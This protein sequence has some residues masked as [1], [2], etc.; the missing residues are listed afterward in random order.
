[1]VRLFAQTGSVGFAAA[2]GFDG[3]YTYDIVTYTGDKFIRLCAQAHAAHLLCAPSVGPGYDAVRA[4]GDHQYKPRR[5][6]DTYDAMWAAGILFGVAGVTD[7]IDGFLAR[8]WHVESRFGKIADPLA[9]RLMIDA[10]VIL[11]VAYGRLPW[12]ALA[13]IIARDLLL[14]A[15]YRVLAPRGIDIDVNLA[16]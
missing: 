4:D 12:A 3:I 11:L 9:D 10:A 13:V 6:G 2:A 14:L 16:G 15:G 8:R 5:G 1:P 7:Q